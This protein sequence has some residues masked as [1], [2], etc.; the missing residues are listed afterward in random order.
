MKYLPIEE[1]HEAIWRLAPGLSVRANGVKLGQWFT[2]DV[3]RWEITKLSCD[4]RQE[5]NVFDHFNFFVTATFFVVMHVSTGMFFESSLQTSYP[6]NYDFYHNL[7]KMNECLRHIST[8]YSE[9]VDVEM[10]YRS[11]FGLSQYVLHITNFTLDTVDKKTDKRSKV[12]L[13]YGEHA[14]EFFP[15]ESMFYFLRKITQGYDMRPG[16]REGNFTRFVLN[17]FDLYL[18]TIVNPDGRMVVETTRNYCWM[19]TANDVD[20]NS[21]LKNG[22]GNGNTMRTIAGVL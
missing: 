2:R 9:F 3:L 1:Q 18:L 7:S 17:N 14:A 11:R 4:Y 21:D 15:V 16:T 19:G 20:L 5:M 10:R 6:P 22:V 13:S 12:L 8:Q